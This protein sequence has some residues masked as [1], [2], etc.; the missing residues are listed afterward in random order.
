MQQVAWKVE[1]STDPGSSSVQDPQFIHKVLNASLSEIY[2]YD[3]TTQQV[4]YVNQTVT[5]TWGYSLEDFQRLG[6]H[7]L[8]DLVHPAD[9]DRVKHHH[10]QCVNLPEHQVLEVEYRIRHRD[11]EWHWLL[12]RD[13]PFSMTAKGLVQQILGTVQNI[14]ARKRSETERQQAEEALRQSEAKNRAIVAAIPD[15]IFRV[16]IDGM[17]RGYVTS[18]RPIDVLSIEFDPT[19]H[20]MTDLLPPELAQRQ[21]HYLQQALATGELQVYE[22]QLQ[23]GDRLQDEEVRVIKSGEDEVLFMVRDISEAKRN[24]ANHQR[25]EKELQANE[26]RYRAI[27]EEQTELVL[28]WSVDRTILFANQS[29]C[30][31][32]GK[33]R[34]ELLGQDILGGMGESVWNQLRSRVEKAIRT[35]SPEHSCCSEAYWSVDAAGQFRFYHWSD[36]GIFDSNGRLTEIQSVGHDITDRKQVEDTLRENEAHQSALLSA[37]PDLVMRINAAGIYLEFITTQNFKVIGQQDDFI[38]THVRDSLPPELAQRRMAALRAALQTRTIQFY[39]QDIFVEGVTQTEEVRVVPYTENEVLLLVRDISDRKQAERALQK[40]VEQEQALNQVIQAIRRSLDLNHIFATATVEIAQLLQADRSAIVQY[41]PDKYCWQHLAEYQRTPDIPS[42]LE[43]NVPDKDNPI[44]AQL[45][46]LEVVLINDSSTLKDEAN[47]KFSHLFPGAWLLVPLIVGQSLWGSFSLFKARQASPWTHE[48]IELAKAT[49][50]HLAIAIQQSKLYHQVQQLNTNLERQVQERTA[51]LQQSLDFE[52]LLKRIT[53]KVRDSLDEQQILQTVVEE[54]AQGLTIECCDT[55]IYN[56]DHTTSTIAYE[57]TKSLVPA[58]GN[59][60]EIA[61]SAHP[62]VYPALFRGQICHFSD[63]ANSPLRTDQNLLTT[64]ACPILDDQG[65]LGDLWL[66]KRAGEIFNDQEVRLVKQVANQCAIGLRQSR[67]YQAAQLQVQELERLNYLKDD[68]LNT[69]SH[70]L[71]TPMSS[72]KM[73]TQMLEI[74]LESLGI[75]ENDSSPINRYFKILREE[76]QREIDL[77]NDLLDLARLEAETE[78]LNA[79][80]I[81]LQMFIP[82]LAEPFVERTRIQQQQLEIEIPE[83]ILPFNTNLSYLARILTELLHNACKYTP[84]G[85]TIKISVQ[86]TPTVLEIWITNSGVEIPAAECDR[87]F[88]KFYRIPNND[89][90]RYGGTGLGLALVRK[91]ADQLGASIRAESRCGQTNFVLGLKPLP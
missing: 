82:H 73:A 53:D 89:P 87:I 78:T 85:E 65:I 81:S 15:L 59:M 10:H 28:R 25:A 41:L 40:R 72:I 27:V 38:G 63:L 21:M 48:E 69:V 36:R 20:Q 22:Q 32:L 5:E 52:A 4:I 12:S 19:G 43:F 66:F 14:T 30:R 42:T 13:T 77:I 16:G 84:A 17:Y 91:L 83:A 70:E 31:F 80:P 18:P 1:M 79:T 49:A 67:L 34:E 37:L 6:S 75:L 2:V 68:F 50:D 51:Q 8:R 11:G 62:E 64:L 76:G 7:A 29:Y 60:F 54:L 46:Q 88:D 57:F 23:L 24:Q 56:A 58:Q 86:T 3:L 9:Y 26:Q 90:W 35:L 39:E 55:G 45:K 33:T 74:H 47:Q 44:A 61:N 71:R